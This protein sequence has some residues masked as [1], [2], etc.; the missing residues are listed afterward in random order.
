MRLLNSHTGALEVFPDAVPRYAILSHT[1]EEEEV[2]FCDFND[3]NID[4]TSMKGWYK[5]KKS[6]QQALLDGLEYVW[7]DTVC[8]DEFFS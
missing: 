8:I 2:C 3:P 7:I 5:V 6:C 4:H 1:W